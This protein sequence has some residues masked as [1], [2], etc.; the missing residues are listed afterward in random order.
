MTQPLSKLAHTGCVVTE[1]FA[2]GLRDD[3]FFIK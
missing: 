2:L 3:F 1:E